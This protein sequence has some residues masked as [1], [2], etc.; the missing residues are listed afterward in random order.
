MNL[1]GKRKFDEFIQNYK[2]V[3]ILDWFVQL[4]YKVWQNTT[5]FQIHQTFVLPVF[6][7]A[8]YIAILWHYEFND[9]SV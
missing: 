3:W 8:S 5:I 2:Y 7:V 9:A 1:F 4:A 6:K